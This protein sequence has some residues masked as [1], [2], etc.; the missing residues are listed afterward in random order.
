M[1]RHLRLILLGGISFLLAAGVSGAG[2]N[3]KAAPNPDYYP[4]Q[5]G[6][7]WNYKLNVNGK[8]LTMITRIAKIETIKDQPY[9]RLEAEVGGKVTATEHL[10]H[11]AEGLIRLRTNDFEADPP[12]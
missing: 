8:E 2:G 11:S 7:Q 4:I 6:N 9:A 5:V 12:L 10:R 1:M 3:K